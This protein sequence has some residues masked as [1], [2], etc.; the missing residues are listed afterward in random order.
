MESSSSSDSDNSGDDELV[1][2]LLD[3][4]ITVSLTEMDQPDSDSSDSTIKRGGS[5]HGKAPNMPCM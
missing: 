4:I 1:T 3:T 5:P 2:V